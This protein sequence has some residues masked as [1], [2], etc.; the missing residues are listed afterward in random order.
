MSE[1]VAD[2]ENGESESTRETETTTDAP[3]DAFAALGDETRLRAIRTV[4]SADEPPSFTELF[5]ASEAETTAGFAYHLRQLAG[6]YLEKDEETERYSLTYAGRSVA[7]A[8]DAGTFTE[9]VDCEPTAIDG[10]CPVCGTEALTARVRDNFVA[11]ACGSCETE[12]LSLPFPPS[13]VSDR[14]TTESLSAFDSYHRNRIELLADGVCPDC[15]GD[16]EAH[17]SVSDVPGLP[18]EESRPVLDADCSSCAFHLR[19]PVSLAVLEHPEVI[20]FFADHGESVRDRPLWNLGPEWSE[21]VLSEDPPAVAVSV[22]LGDE[23]LRLLVGDGPTVV[24]V[25]R[26]SLS[27]DEPTTQSTRDQAGHETADDSAITAHDADDSAITTHDADEDP[28]AAES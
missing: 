21:T 13:G 20:S 15:A 14:D 6:R 18:G 9:R 5:E 28:A 1:S 12:L 7:R 10:N 25:R 3:D 4:A 22:E 8:L 24:D 11:V 19:T 17:I 26:E 23:R 16:A 27:R 2:E